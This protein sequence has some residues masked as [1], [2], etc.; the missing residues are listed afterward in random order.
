MTQPNRPMDAATDEALGII[1][2]ALERSRAADGYVRAGLER[3]GQIRAKFAAPTTGPHPQH[4][5][6]DHQLK[7]AT[8]RI[9][10]SHPDLL[11]PYNL[12]YMPRVMEWLDPKEYQQ[13]LRSVQKPVEE[14][15]KRIERDRKDYVRRNPEGKFLSYG[16]YQPREV[17][18]RLERLHYAPL[19]DCRAPIPEPQPPI[20]TRI[21]SSIRSSTNAFSSAASALS[22]SSRGA[23]SSGRRGRSDDQVPLLR[24]GR[25]PSRSPSPGQPG[26]SAAPSR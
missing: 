26:R 18:A 21:H 10:N 7:K 16:Y 15:N 23:G 12:Q 24:Q 13:R 6:S 8:T 5:V 20:S 3:I 9:I 1:Q 4:Q 17:P 25:S 22:T 19:A 11:E 14:E 2:T